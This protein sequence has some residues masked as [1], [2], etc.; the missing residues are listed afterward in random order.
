MA[1]A[2][3]HGDQAS[4]SSKFVATFVFSVCVGLSIVA[5]YFVITY[6]ANAKALFEPKLG[7]QKKRNSPSHALHLSM[8]EQQ[9]LNHQISKLPHEE[10]MQHI[11]LDG[12]VFILFIES[13]IKICIF[14]AAFGGL[15]LIPLYATEQRDEKMTFEYDL[16]EVLSIKHLNK[17][18][19]RLWISVVAAYLFVIG[20]LKILY[21][22]G[23]QVA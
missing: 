12:V 23:I 19:V 11:G 22:T 4:D 5:A 6:Y 7:Q 2:W 17:N 15:I 16:V 20:A 1:D 8:T 10:L 9:L 3:R 13:C 21:D 14:C 18:S